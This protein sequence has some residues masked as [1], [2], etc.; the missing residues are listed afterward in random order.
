MR[1]PYLTAPSL[2]A[3]DVQENVRSVD[4]QMVLAQ[5][6]LAVSEVVTRPE[7][8]DED[9]LPLT[10]IREELDDEGN[11]I[12]ICPN[13]SSLSLWLTFVIASSS[14]R[15]GDTGPQ[16]VEALRKAGVKEL[17]ETLA[18]QP[19]TSNSPK[20]RVTEIQDNSPA[21]AI[22]VPQTDTEEWQ[23]TKNEVNR[24]PE[25]AAKITLNKDDVRPLGRKKS[26]SFAEGTKT[27]DSTISRKRLPHPLFAKPKPAP[28]ASKT[29][30]IAEVKAKTPEG[31]LSSLLH[32]ESNI[33]ASRGVS[34]SDPDFGTSV[35]PDKESPEDAAMRWQMLQY[36]MQEVRSVVAEIELDEQGEGSTPP[37]SSDEDEDDYDSSV[38]EEEDE[39]GR[40][41][42]VLLGDEYIKEMQALENRL[43]ASLIRNV[44]PEATNETSLSHSADG[45][46]PES[47]S[48]NASVASSSV[49][50]KGV[51][52]AD[53]VDIQEAPILNDSTNSSNTTTASTGTTETV[54]PAPGTDKKKVSRFKSER[55]TSTFAAS[56]PPE[57]DT[58]AAA[59]AP[60][61]SRV[62]EHT[63]SSTLSSTGPHLPPAIPSLRPPRPPPNGPSDRTLAENIIERPYTTIA[64]P[65]TTPQEPDEFDPALLHQEATTEYHR[66][67]NRMIYRQGG[68]LPKEEDEDEV[69]LDAEGKEQGRKVSR[70]MAARL[71]RK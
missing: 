25:H 58:I 23:T 57:A 61:L 45:K 54:A 29:E 6:K 1:D 21:W 60:I 46:L 31:Q 15:T 55:A 65:D 53:K 28:A 67:R 30:T 24:L 64:N 27:E 42:N 11:I 8:R 38:E 35:I 19:S 69:L 41:T 44:G 37:Y 36:N 7:A 18:S 5:Q 2:L 4:K 9:G 12:C 39:H 56:R 33:L 13:H 26:V 22:D 20:D 14:T 32:A 43:D 59:N 47:Q 52:F 3:G 63:P 10:E 40:A 48:R 66:Q 49:P 62:I 51:R 50:T 16:V 17:S 70:F 71:G 68:F 34:S